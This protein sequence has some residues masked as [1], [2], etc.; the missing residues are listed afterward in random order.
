LKEAC[1]LLIDMANERGGEDN[2][3]VLIAQVSSG[4]LRPAE[5]VPEV[6]DERATAP[7]SGEL[8]P[9]ERWGADTLPRDPNLPAYVDDALL[10]DEEATIPPEED[11]TLRPDEDATSSSSE[12]GE[13]KG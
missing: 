9:S 7:M 12:N 2:I 5:V 8:I 1:D 6:F 3:T 4:R 13:D 11:A 10:D